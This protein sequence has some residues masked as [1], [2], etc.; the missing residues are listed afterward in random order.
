MVER[1]SPWT[2]IFDVEDP[3]SKVPQYKGKFLDV[4]QALEVARYDL[5]YCD[6]KA[7]QDVLT[8]MLLHE[9]VLP[10]SPLYYFV[11]SKIYFKVFLS[12][13][14]FFGYASI[15]LRSML[16]Y[17]VLNLYASYSGWLIDLEIFNRKM[18]VGC[19]STEPSCSRIQIYRNS[20]EG[21]SRVTGGTVTSPQPGIVYAR[22]NLSNEMENVKISFTLLDGVNGYRSFSS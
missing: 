5:H 12:I 3:R 18:H 9:K 8:I 21:A 19:G 15:M 4:N 10:L 22:I 17:A 6:W 20:S 14:L 1:K 7:R 13:F 11:C 16:F 2:A